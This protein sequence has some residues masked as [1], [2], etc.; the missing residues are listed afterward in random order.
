LRTAGELQA[1]I[2]LAFHNRIQSDSNRIQYASPPYPEKGCAH[3]DRVLAS[4][5]RSRVEEPQMNDKANL[6]AK[7]DSFSDQ[8]SPRIVATYNGNDVCVT[9]LQG[10]FIWH[11]HHDTDDLFLVL[12]GQLEI[13]LR[14]RI[15]ELS[16][17]DLFVVPKGA[18]HRPCARHGEVKL[19]LMES[20]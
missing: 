8:W 14:D 10:E 7:L 20:A 2:V 5:G 4:T 18:E 12:E 16:P 13:E 3:G 1:S 6:K 11:K 9:R 17:G 15:V 19:L